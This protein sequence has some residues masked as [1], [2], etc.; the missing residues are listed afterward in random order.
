MAKKYKGYFIDLDGT[1]YA[2]KKRIPAAKRF[3]EQ[4]QAT[5]TAFFCLSRIIRQSYPQ[6]S[7]ET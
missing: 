7:S 4:L 5:Q 6:M 3:I 1:V 2:G